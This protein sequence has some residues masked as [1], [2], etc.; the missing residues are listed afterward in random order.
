MESD[1]LGNLCGVQGSLT[2]QINVVYCVH[3]DTPEFWSGKTAVLLCNCTSARVTL[4][5]GEAVAVASLTDLDAC[6]ALRPSR[7][8]MAQELTC[9][10]HA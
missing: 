8:V 4:N 3:V 1:L 5:A 9:P 2:Q 7:E 6:L 10:M